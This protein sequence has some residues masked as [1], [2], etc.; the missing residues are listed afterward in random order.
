MDFGPV[1][2]VFGPLA[3]DFGPLAMDF[4]PVAFDLPLHQASQ[5]PFNSNEPYEDSCLYNSYKQ[6]F[7]VMITKL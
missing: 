6:Y 7:S 3:M 2:M 1:A 4:G 5:P